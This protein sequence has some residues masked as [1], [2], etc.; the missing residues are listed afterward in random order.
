M[1]RD[2]C[3]DDSHFNPIFES[4]LCGMIEVSIPLCGPKI[5]GLTEFYHMICAIFVTQLLK[6]FQ[7]SDR[8]PGSF[9]GEAFDASMTLKAFAILGF[10]ILGHFFNSDA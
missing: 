10:H 7:L 5:G 2:R 8:W 9:D 1:F 3:K 6:V 4:T